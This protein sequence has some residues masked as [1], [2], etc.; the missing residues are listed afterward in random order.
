MPPR[1]WRATLAW[2]TRCSVVAHNVVAASASR[3]GNADA[4]TGSGSA[5]SS[6]FFA[7]TSAQAEA[8]PAATRAEL[9]K[10]ASPA[11]AESGYG[12]ADFGHSPFER[13]ETPAPAA[14]QSLPYVLP[15]Q[16]QTG[17]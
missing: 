1:S 6:I 4:T 8:A 2:R 17:A 13:T 3:T 16:P 14:T 7:M 5:K 9:A 11:Q 10:V 15:S 12:V